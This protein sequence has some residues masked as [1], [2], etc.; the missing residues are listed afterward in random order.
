MQITNS[1]QHFFNSVGCTYLD[2]HYD[3]RTWNY[4]K[5]P[6]T[7]YCGCKPLK[8]GTTYCEKHADQMGR[9][10]TRLPTRHADLRRANAI[11]DLTSEFNSVLE[12]LVAA[13]EVSL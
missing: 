9:K 8:P 11:W 2:Q 1:D 6:L 10:K 7:P 13:G 12:D 3:P 4:I 5:Q